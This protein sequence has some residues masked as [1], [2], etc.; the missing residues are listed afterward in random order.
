MVLL[1]WYN[2]LVLLG[3]SSVKFSI[4]IVESSG[5]GVVSLNPGDRTVG[6]PGRGNTVLDERLIEFSGLGDM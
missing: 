3:G 4:T 2:C 6:L 1:T 5:C